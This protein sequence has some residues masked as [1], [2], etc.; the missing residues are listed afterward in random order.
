MEEEN[1]N[2]YSLNSFCCGKPAMLRVIN[3]FYLNQFT[4]FLEYECRICGLKGG[5]GFSEKEAAELF[6][7]FF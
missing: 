1:F 3:V 5:K 2:L 4:N 6:K 7:E